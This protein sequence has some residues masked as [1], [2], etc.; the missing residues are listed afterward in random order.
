MWLRCAYR[1]GGVFFSTN[2]LLPPDEDNR[3]FLFI[4]HLRNPSSL[5][6]HWWR[7]SISQGHLLLLL[8]KCLKVIKREHAIYLALILFSCFSYSFITSTYS[9]IS[10]I[11][12]FIY[13]YG[14]LDIPYLSWLVIVI[15]II[16]NSFSSLFFLPQPIPWPLN[17][18]PWM[19]SFHNLWNSFQFERKVKNNG[20]WIMKKTVAGW[21]NK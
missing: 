1:Y 18:T 7:T 16:S 12:F 21:C 9:Y 5:S 14:I 3:C 2:W 10:C 19:K 11:I 15:V 17:V 13:L 8:K 6:L 4:I 20:W